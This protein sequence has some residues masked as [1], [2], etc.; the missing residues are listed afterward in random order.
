[1]KKILVLGLVAIMSLSLISMTGC[2]KNN[3]NTDELQIVESVDD[4]GKRYTPTFMYFVSGADADFDKAME[5]VVEL[6]AEYGE[7]IKFDIHNI[8]ETPED[9]E[10]FPV[11]GMTPALIMLDTK[12]NISAMEFKCTDI[13]KLKNDIDMALAAQ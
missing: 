5:V 10:N 1:M 3:E 9:K 11:D 12:N 2:K 13:E 4:D 6:K 7:K 8:D